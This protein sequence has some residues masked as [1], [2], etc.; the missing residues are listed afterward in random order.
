M[1]IE[2][3]SKGHPSWIAE[4]EGME[5]DAASTTSGNKLDS[6][7]SGRK[8]CPHCNKNFKADFF[9]KHLRVHN[10]EKTWSCNKCDKS[11]HYKHDLVRH[12]TLEHVADPRCEFCGEN[13]KD[14]KLLKEH[15]TPCRR[16]Y[17][18]ERLSIQKVTSL[19]KIE[20]NDEEKDEKV[21]QD[22]D[23]VQNKEVLQDEEVVQEEEVD[24]NNCSTQEGTNVM[25]VEVG[26]TIVGGPIVIEEVSIIDGGYEVEEGT[27]QIT[28]GLVTAGD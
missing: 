28:L 11:Y 4:V 2:K 9:E 12:V 14:R 15:R 13:F 10:K 16:M 6:S 24:Y 27:H 23:V 19:V 1:Y 17:K 25:Q 22:E 26:D 21:V 7:S 8:Q 5:E 3:R 18:K 20:N